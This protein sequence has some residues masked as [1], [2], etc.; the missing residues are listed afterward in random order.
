MWDFL[1]K[2]FLVLST[3]ASGIALFAAMVALAGYTAAFDARL[4]WVIEYPDLIKVGLVFLAT[5]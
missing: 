4:M 5:A 1:T 3:F 2:N